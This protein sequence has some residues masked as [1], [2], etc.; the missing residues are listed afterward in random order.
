[1]NTL[2]K[3]ALVFRSGP[4]KYL[5]V[6]GLTMA[7]ACTFAAALETTPPTN[8]TSC[9]TVI[10]TPG[11]YV[12]RQDLQSTSKTVDCIQIAVPSVNLDLGANLTGLGTDDVSAAGISV[13][14]SAKGVQVFLGNVTV[15]GFGIGI[16]VAGSGVT[17]SGRAGNSEFPFTVQNNAAQGILIS[18]ASTVLIDGLISENNGGAGLELSGA[19][20]VIVQGSPALTSNGKYGVWVHSSSGNQFFDFTIAGN[21]GG[22]IY[23]GESSP[24]GPGQVPL[25]RLDA[26]GNPGGAG[27]SPAPIH[28]RTSNNGGSQNNVF[29]GGALQFNLGVGIT[30][31]QGDDFN[32]VTYVSGSNDEGDDAVDLNGDCTHNSW[33]FNKFT[34]VSPACI[35]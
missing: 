15:Q 20:G 17:I 30:I 6:M 7:A 18:N 33:Q 29:F 8:I 10:K 19:S 25:Q 9:G 16:K 3:L 11:Y 1:M 34:T 28:N 24:A 13:L 2:R 5:L 23:V 31:G 26:P 4:T 14:N 21:Q 22:G 35:Q 12:V 27:L 32:V